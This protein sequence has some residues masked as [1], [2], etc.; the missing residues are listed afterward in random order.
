MMIMAS[1]PCLARPPAKRLQREARQK[2]DAQPS[3]QGHHIRDAEGSGTGMPRDQGGQHQEAE[4]LRWM[5]T[6]S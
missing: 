6:A 1:T 5:R 3:Y 2:T 4:S